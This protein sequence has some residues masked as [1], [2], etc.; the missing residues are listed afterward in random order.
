MLVDDLVR[1]AGGEDV[2]DVA[3]LAIDGIVQSPCFTALLRAAISG[4]R[5]VQLNST[6]Q[7]KI[8]SD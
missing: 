4:A 8:L 7:V 2:V 6:Y 5:H 1:E 3:A